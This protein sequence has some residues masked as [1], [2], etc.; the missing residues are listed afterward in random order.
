MFGGSH[1]SAP[2]LSHFLEDKK[3]LKLLSEMEGRCVVGTQ[4]VQCH[5]IHPVDE[6]W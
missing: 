5:Y 6:E 4:Q 3:Q 1:H 2:L